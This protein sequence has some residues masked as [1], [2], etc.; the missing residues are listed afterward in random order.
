MLGQVFGIDFVPDEFHRRLSY[1]QI[2]GRPAYSALRTDVH[3]GAYRAA[4]ASQ[5]WTYKC[6]WLI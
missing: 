3:Y 4:G 6:N 2:Q 1:Y 5:M